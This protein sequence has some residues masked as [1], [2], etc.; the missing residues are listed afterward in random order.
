MI[1]GSIAPG[2]RAGDPVRVTVA[3]VDVPARECDLALDEYGQPLIVYENGAEL[4]FA[5]GIDVVSIDEDLEPRALSREPEPTVLSGSSVQSL[6]SKVI[7][8]ALGRRVL[9][10]R[11]GIFF[12]RDEGRWAGDAGRIRKVVIAR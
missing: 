9:N 3:R 10:P 7:F 11:S 4:W 2:R 8:D 1:V 5:K 6:A 12:V